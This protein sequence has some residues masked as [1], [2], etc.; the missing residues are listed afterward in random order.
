MPVMVCPAV[1]SGD[2]AEARSVPPPLSWVSPLA[3]VAS[4]RGP[5]CGRARAAS[6]RGETA[7]GPVD[8]RLIFQL[9]M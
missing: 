2:P 5:G 7:L 6:R 4:A 9:S 3:G 8:Y 1:T